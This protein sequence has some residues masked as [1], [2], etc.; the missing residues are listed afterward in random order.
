MVLQLFHQANLCLLLYRLVG[1][2]VLTHTECIVSPD[3]LDRNLHQGCD[4]NSWFHIVGEYKECTHCCYHATVKHH[5]DTHIC[6]GKLGYTSLEECSREVTT[7]HALGL[8]EEAVGLVGVR[9]VGRSADHVRNL[10]CQNTQTSSR[11]CTGG[12]TCLLFYLAPVYLWSLAREPLIHLGALLRVGLAPFCLG[13]LTLGNNLLQLLGTLGVEF[14][15]IVEDNEWIL[16]VSTEVLDSID[17]GISTERSAMSID[18]SLIACTIGTQG[19]LAHHG[20]TNDKGRTLLLLLSCCEGFTNLSYVVA[21]NLDDIPSPCLIF[22]LGVF[23][24]HNA[25]LCREL[26]IVGVVEHDEVVQTQVACNTAYTLRDFLLYG[27]IRDVCI[28]FVLHHGRAQTC[29]KELLGYGS[30]SCN[31]MSLT[32]WTA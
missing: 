14:F 23:G 13:S 1:R 27:T 12:R 6:H 24:H 5:T 3:E 22:H 18:A 16:R 30:T 11:C 8:L 10:F 17:I 9:E 21:I 19:S 25:T 2:S 29:L 15:Y 31:G 20:F 26:D 28:D 4:T 7:Y 32:Q